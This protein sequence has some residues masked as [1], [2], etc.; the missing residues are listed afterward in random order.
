MSMS[1]HADGLLPIM[2]AIMGFALQ[3]TAEGSIPITLVPAQLQLPVVLVMLELCVLQPQ[4]MLLRAAM[5]LQFLLYS[6]NTAWGG[7]ALAKTFSAL[8]DAM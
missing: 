2:V 7:A 5:K 6:Q 3:A 8:Y 1:L 4:C